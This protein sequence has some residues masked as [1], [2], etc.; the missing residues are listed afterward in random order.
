MTRMTERPLS[1]SDLSHDEE[2]IQDKM[3]TSVQCGTN[4][5]KPLSSR[6]IPSSFSYERERERSF[7]NKI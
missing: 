6:G 2:N 1:P 5:D 4:H 3:D 7:A